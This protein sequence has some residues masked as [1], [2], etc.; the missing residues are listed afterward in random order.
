M[1]QES[2]EFFNALLRKYHGNTTGFLARLTLEM[3]G[4]RICY[5]SMIP[6]SRLNSG[7]Q[8][9]QLLQSKDPS[10]VDCFESKRLFQSCA[11]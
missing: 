2:S 1:G 6:V 3:W 8:R 5:Y 4:D 9:R 10:G 7:S 11:G